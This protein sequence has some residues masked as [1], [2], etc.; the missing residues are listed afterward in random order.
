MTMYG[1]WKPVRSCFQADFVMYEYFILPM[2]WTPDFGRPARLR[3]GSHYG[4]KMV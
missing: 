2:L 3:R 4:L 1:S